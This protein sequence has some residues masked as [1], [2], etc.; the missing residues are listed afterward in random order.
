MCE[1]TGKG[2]VVDFDPTSRSE[3]GRE[4]VG[5]SGEILATFAQGREAHFEHLEPVVEVA[6]QGP[7]GDGAGEIGRDR[8]EEARER[9][10]GRLDPT[11]EEGLLVGREGGEIFNDEDAALGVGQGLGERGGAGGVEDEGALF[12]SRMFADEPGDAGFA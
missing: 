11:N 12:S 8:G 10:P 5:E 4:K 3:L 6:A 1:E 9:R 2:F 7:S